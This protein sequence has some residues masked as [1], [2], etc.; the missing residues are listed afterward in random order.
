MLVQSMKWTLAAALVFSSALQYPTQGIAQTKLPTNTQ[1]PPQPT[2]KP[3]SPKQPASR[4]VFVWPKTPPRLTTV[5]G[6][7]TGMGSRNHCPAVGTGLTALV[8]VQ[9]QEVASKHINT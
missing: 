3:A 4:P 9:E 2:N 8:P 5:S 6:R 1:Q 7:R